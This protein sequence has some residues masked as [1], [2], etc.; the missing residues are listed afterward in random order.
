MVGIFIPYCLPHHDPIKSDNEKHR[1]H[2]AFLSYSTGDIELVAYCVVVDNATREVVFEALDNLDEFLSRHPYD[3]SFCHRLFLLILSKSLSKSTN[4]IV[5][6]YSIL[7][8][9]PWRFL[10]HLTPSINPACFFSYNFNC[11]AEFHTDNLQKTLLGT[12][13]VIP[14]QFVLS[15][16]LLFYRSFTISPLH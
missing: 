16:L 6:W 12:D 3:L 7:C 2:D 9:V 1:W 10:M 5:I 4:I 13:R 15:I 8:T 11:I 14:R